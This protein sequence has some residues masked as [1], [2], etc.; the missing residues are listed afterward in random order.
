MPI[1]CRPMPHLRGVFVCRSTTYSRLSVESIFQ[2]YKS[3][4]PFR[5]LICMMSDESWSLLRITV[6]DGSRTKSPIS[7]AHR[8]YKHRPEAKLGQR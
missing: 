2:E 5:V 8:R 1:V 6:P 7:R 4:F 3:A